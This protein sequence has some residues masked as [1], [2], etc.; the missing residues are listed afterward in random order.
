MLY[1]VLINTF[2]FFI[3]FQNQAEC[4]IIKENEALRLKEMEEMKKR[5]E[6]FTES[7]NTL[8]RNIQDLQTEICDKNKVY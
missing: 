8:K 4:M 3:S 2:L 1:I 6:A 7:E 5:I